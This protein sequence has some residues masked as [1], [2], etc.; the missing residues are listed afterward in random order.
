MS[1]RF[2]VATGFLVLSCLAG[3]SA[4]AA[5]GVDMSGESPQVCSAGI[6]PPGAGA[7][8]NGVAIGQLREF[9]N[10]SDGYEVWI[11]F[12]SELVG[13]VLV[14]DGQDLSL[15]EARTVRVSH[16]AGPG[17]AQHRLQLRPRT[18]ARSVTL[19]VRMLPAPASLAKED[20]GL[21]GPD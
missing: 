1:S 11:D 16:A 12:P 3:G 2:P 6:D 8:G 13:A 5:P 15:T 10:A 17:L 21:S 7:G 14:V 19:T 4:M 18:A 20:K 9:C